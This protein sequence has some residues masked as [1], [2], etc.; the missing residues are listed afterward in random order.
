MPLWSQ[1]LASCV[2]SG[3]AGPANPSSCV[4][5]SGIEALQMPGPLLITD[6]HPTIMN[7]SNVSRTTFP[8]IAPWASLDGGIVFCLFCQLSVKMLSKHSTDL[9]QQN[10]AALLFPACAIA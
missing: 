9:S 1:P 8:F 2:I 4:G 6:P 10:S 3:Y 7:D 5:K